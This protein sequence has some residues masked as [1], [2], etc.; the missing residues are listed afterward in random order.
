LLLHAMGVL[1][2][3][4]HSVAHPALSSHLLLFDLLYKLI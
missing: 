1:K 4:S 3:N 2:A